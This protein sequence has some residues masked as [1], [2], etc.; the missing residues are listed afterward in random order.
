[1]EVMRFG[2]CSSWKADPQIR[3]WQ[4]G[5][6]SGIFFYG[7]TRMMLKMGGVLEVGGGR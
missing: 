3:D 7:V 1:M 2:L 6:I 5:V 4:W